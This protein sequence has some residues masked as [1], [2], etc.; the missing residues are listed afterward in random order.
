MQRCAAMMPCVLVVDDDAVV[1][2]GLR[3]MLE[4]LGLEVL[5]AGTLKEAEM[6]SS[7]YEPA[8]LL[9]DGILPDGNGIEWVST[10]RNEGLR[11]EV[12]LMSGRPSHQI[13]DIVAHATSLRS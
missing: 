10:L 12:V 5:E 2:D 7:L 13:A 8:L 9:V 4:A 6:V 11:S 3:A 1:R